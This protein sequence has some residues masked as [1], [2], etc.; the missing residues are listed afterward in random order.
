M[1]HGST[2]P[3]TYYT[4]LHAT[5]RVFNVGIDLGFHVCTAPFKACSRPR[6]GFYILG[7]GLGFLRRLPSLFRSRGK[8]RSLAVTL[9]W[10]PRNVN[11]GFVETSS[12]TTVG[13]GNRQG[14]FGS[15][16]FEIRSSTKIEHKFGS[17]KNWQLPT[18]A[19][20]HP[21]RRSS[22]CCNEYIAGF[23]LMKLPRRRKWRNW[24]LMFIPNC[25]GCHE[26]AKNN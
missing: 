3:N 24:W 17:P 18:I 22:L 7:I 19:V 13:P 1:F 14:A 16:P 21:P 15:H 4:H 9:L 8:R 6:L 5:F 26:N 20:C 25:W 10:V 11:L 23:V 12:W 2:A